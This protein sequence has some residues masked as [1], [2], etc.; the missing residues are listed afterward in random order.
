MQGEIQKLVKMEDLLQERIVGQDEAVTL[1]ANAV[2]RSRSGLADPH[3]P[4]LIFYGRSLNS[5]EIARW[6]KAV[7]QI[8]WGKTGLRTGL[9]Q[10]NLPD[11]SHYRLTQM[12]DEKTIGETVQRLP[13]ELLTAFDGPQ[14]NQIWARRRF[15]ILHDGKNKPTRPTTIQKDTAIAHPL[16]H[17]WQPWN[18]APLARAPQIP[19]RVPMAV[20]QN[21]YSPENFV[22]ITRDANKESDP[23]Q[24]FIVYSFNSKSNQLEGE[25]ARVEVLNKKEE[26]NGLRLTVAREFQDFALTATLES[27]TQNWAAWQYPHAET[28]YVPFGEV[29]VLGSPAASSAAPSTRKSSPAPVDEISFKRAAASYNGFMAGIGMSVEDWEEFAL[30]QIRISPR[31]RIPDMATQFSGSVLEHLAS[32]PPR[33]SFGKYR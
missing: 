30:Q 10:L 6:G 1:I 27:W 21:P 23:R 8:D 33:V 7:S 9:Q 11:N 2:R 31:N 4:V 17:A 19:G 24:T 20:L 12:Y 3:R 15:I 16:R 13:D 18:S 25:A 28:P 26:V 22:V 29:T 5:P 32:Q 14:K